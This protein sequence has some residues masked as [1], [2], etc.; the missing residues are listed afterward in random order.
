MVECNT[1]N[2]AIR[3]LSMV[4]CPVEK[5]A[6]VTPF[7][8]CWR[9]LFIPSLEVDAS[10]F[11]REFPYGWKSFWYLNVLFLGY[12]PVCFKNNWSNGLWLQKRIWSLEIILHNH[13]AE[14]VSQMVAK[15]CQ[16]G[17]TSSFIEYKQKFGGVNCSDDMNTLQNCEQWTGM[18]SVPSR[19]SM[20]SIIQ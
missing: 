15:L 11:E 5:W 16:N 12:L 20:S 14:Y 8:L 7:V 6:R 1:C 19:K 9:T 13:I 10:I 2:G 4:V 18:I 3:Q 17:N